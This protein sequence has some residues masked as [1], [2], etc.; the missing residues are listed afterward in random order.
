MKITREELKQ[1]VREV[2]QENHA[3]IE[4]EERFEDLYFGLQKLISRVSKNNK[5][6]G[7]A[8]ELT[9]AFIDLLYAVE[10]DR[11]GV[12]E[13]F[14]ALK[15]VRGKISKNA[16]HENIEKEYPIW[17]I[18]P[19]K[20]KEELL[21]TKATSKRQARAIALYLTDKH[22]CTKVRIQVLDLAQDPADIWDTDKLFKE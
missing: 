13:I 19:G 6:K 21:Y 15:K 16:I 7:Y 17:G 22:G 20:N 4:T 12:G 5:V 3:N 2:I 18:P 8:G 11:L 14:N 10:T 1:L 9:H